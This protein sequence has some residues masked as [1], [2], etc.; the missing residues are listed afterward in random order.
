MFLPVST[1]SVAETA[2]FCV[3]KVTFSDVEPE[4]CWD[5]EVFSCSSESVWHRNLRVN[6]R[7]KNETKISIPFWAHELNNIKGHHDF[8][9][10]L[11]ASWYI[12]YCRDSGIEIGTIIKGHLGS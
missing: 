9:E 2:H 7:V 8:C 10:P 5:D 1:F 3:D 6:V 4:D 12:F 11:F